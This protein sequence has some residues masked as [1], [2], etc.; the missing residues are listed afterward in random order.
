M[1]AVLWQQETDANPMVGALF[2]AFFVGVFGFIVAHRLTTSL[3]RTRDLAGTTPV[4][5]Q[6]RTLALCLACL[7]PATVGVVVAVFM[8]VTA[9][10]WTP[11]G[12]PVSAHVAWFRD[13]PA[14]DVL[15]TLVAAGPVAALGGPLLGVAVARWAPFRGSALIGVVTLVFLTAM[16]S[17]ASMPWR[18][19]SVW[20][21]LVDE[22][23]NE[24]GGP[25]VRS[26]FVAG[27]E[28]IWVLCYL[29]CL[30]GLA[31][32][33]ALLRDPDHRRPLLGAGAALDPRRG[34][35]LPARTVMRTSAPREVVGAAAAA[36]VIVVVASVAQPDEGVPRLVVLICELLLAGGAAYLLDDAA[37]ALT[38]VTPVGVWRRRRPR[39]VSGS[40]LLATTW[41]LALAVLWSQDSR[42]PLGVVTWELS[43]MCLVALAAAAVLAARGESEP[44]GLVA[45]AV[46]LLGI[47]AL[48]ADQF[49]EAALFVPWDGSGGL[50]VHLAWV[51][52]GGTAVLVIAVASRDPAQPGRL[53]RA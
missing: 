6:Q 39:L 18:I 52:L 8:L 44:G 4:G 1:G 48:I 22:H 5:R 24:G 42:P 27:V 46:G 37:V 11:V 28:P 26:N 20:P 16:P 35:V 15:A 25:V 30:C 53:R 34:R 12:D 41:V 3:L 13:D 47:G 9:A 36:V 21:I 7:V 19:V 10:I 45:P 32:V 50:E 43:A 14:L 49:V 17:E 23:I 33:A 51:V 29:I 38:T 40:A 31:V 2:I